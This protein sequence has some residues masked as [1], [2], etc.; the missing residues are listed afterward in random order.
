MKEN[1]FFVTR[2][3]IVDVKNFPKKYLVQIEEKRGDSAFESEVQEGLYYWYGSLPL[4][5]H[6]LEVW[7]LYS[8]DSS[9]AHCIQNIL[10]YPV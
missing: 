9:N 1:T 6:N 7:Y 5:H 2:L 3:S 10:R 4:T 8:K